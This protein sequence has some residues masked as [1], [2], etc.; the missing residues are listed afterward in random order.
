[1]EWS[2][3]RLPQDITLALD[4]NVGEARGLMRMPIAASRLFVALEPYPKQR[5][6]CRSDE[7]IRTIE[8]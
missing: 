8:T 7:Y 6:R 2:K 4:G 5:A 3:F 1:M